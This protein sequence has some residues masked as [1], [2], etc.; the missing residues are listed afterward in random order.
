MSMSAQDGDNDTSI[1]L[2]IVGG[3]TALVVAGVVAYA[4][5]SGSKGA[6][7]TEAPVEVGGTTAM[8]DDATHVQDAMPAEVMNPSAET[9]TS[10][11]LPAATVG[12]IFFG[13]GAIRVDESQQAAL[14]AAVQALAA[15]SAAAAAL[16]G[17]H[18]STGSLEANQRVAKARALAVRDALI[19][20]GV[21]ES[22]IRLE[23]PQMTLGGTSPELSRRVD[24]LLVK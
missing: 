22:R 15:D 5:S 21:D 13:S 16:S 24:I 2:W 14:G 1:G 9:M 4:A 8:L 3:V 7:M 10:A 12:Q 17:F 20:Q 11:P 18:D 19:A 6:A 23:K